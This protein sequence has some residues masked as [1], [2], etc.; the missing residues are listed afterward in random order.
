MERIWGWIRR[1]AFIEG[2]AVGALICHYVYH[3]FR[4]DEIKERYEAKEQVF[5]SRLSTKDNEIATLN[6]SLG[7]AQQY[8]QKYVTEASRA[9][10]LDRKLGD[11]T[12]DR[13]GLSRRYADLLAM[14][15]E[16][17]YNAE[18][19]SRM[20]LEEEA[21][22]LRQRLG[23]AETGQATADPHLVK[24]IYMLTEQNKLL[25]R[26]RDELRRLYS[27]ASASTARASQTT[28]S[29]LFP[30][31]ALAGVSITDVGSTIIAV[32][33]TLKKPVDVPSFIAALAKASITDRGDVVRSCAPALAF[34]LTPEQM[35]A[36]SQL[37]SITDSGDAM[38]LLL[39]EQGKH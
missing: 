12:V 28:G 36:I 10:V 8:E 25:Q 15:W 27:T 16:E 2:L 33:A 31:D 32:T 39:Q 14:K 17:K 19:L 23:N 20:S 38:R 13:E 6:S 3:E 21:A 35:K 4:I 24:Q 5:D 1:W 9:L 18:K 34:P 30:V 11:L 37:I 29:T 26:E 22:S 7:K